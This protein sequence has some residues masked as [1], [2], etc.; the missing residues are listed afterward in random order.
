MIMVDRK[1]PSKAELIEILNVLGRPGISGES[2]KAFTS[3]ED[4]SEYAVWLVDDGKEKSVLKKAKEYELKAYRAYFPSGKPYV[5]ALLG[6]CIFGESEYFLTEYC[7]GTDL[8]ICSREKLT[9]ALDA[10]T[11]MQDEFWQREDMYDTCVSMDRALAAIAEDGKYL[12]SELLERTY[13]K[14]TDIYRETPR[15]VCHE[16][17]LPINLIINEERAVITDW[18]YAGILP[19]PGPFALLIAHGR[20]DPDSY[21]FMSDE[22]KSFAVGYYYDN[23]VKKHGIPFD[24]YRHVLDY[25]IFHEYCEWIMLGNRYGNRDDERYGYYMKLAEDLAQRLESL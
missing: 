24:E 1:I 21:F 6:S 23:L 16:D 7:P 10:L 15:T 17:L 25:F 11:R 18:E 5:P 19:Y 2:V 4:G 22:D 8:R 14:F 12:G 9:K 20:N 13:S 3:D